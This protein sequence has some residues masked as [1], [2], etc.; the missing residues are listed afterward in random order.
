ME[1][2]WAGTHRLW[3]VTTRV[4]AEPGEPIS[5]NT[6]RAGGGGGVRVTL[7][8]NTIEFNVIKV[9]AAS[10]A[11][12]LQEATSTY[13]YGTAGQQKEAAHRLRF[14]STK[15]SVDTLGRLFWLNDQP[16][17][18]DLM[19]GLFGSPY[20]A[21]A[22]GAMQREISSPDHPITEDFLETLSKLQVAGEYPAEP[23]DYPAGLRSWADKW[24]KIYAH[25]R[26]LKKAAFTATVAALPKKVGRAHAITVE[27]L[28]TERSDWLV[29]ETASQL[30]RQLIAD[31]GDLPEWTR[32]DLIQNRWPLLEGPEMLPILV[33]IVSHPVPHF[34]YR[35]EESRSRDEALKH[36][37]ELDPA[38]GRSLI[39]RDLNDPKAQPSIS[40][41][42]LLSPKE[43]QPVVQQAVRRIETSD[44]RDVDYSIVELFADKSALGSLEAKF[45]VDNDHL[46]KGAGACNPR[47]VAMLRYFLRLDPKFGATAVQALLAARKVNGCDRLLED[48][49][50]SLP[51]VEQQAIRALDDTNPTVATEA[52]RALGQWGSAKAE[53]ALWARLRRFHQEWPNGVADLP[54]TDEDT[55]AQVR[56][57]D[58]LET[59][60]VRSTVSG[61]NWICDP[62]KLMRLRELVSWQNR[63]DLSQWIDAWE[64]TD[65]P[66]IIDPNYWGPEDRLSFSIMQLPYSNLDEEQIRVK[67]AQMPRGAKLYF[68]TFTAEQ[69]GS[70]VSM[71]KQQAVLQRLRKYAA[72]FDVIIDERP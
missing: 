33:E 34:P 6:F 20:R 53:P 24:D 66:L 35:T 5:L 12:Q 55:S 65:G 31:W 27:T 50:K 18:W 9:D 29:K 7:R 11:E 71:E 36:I 52:A 69:M 17:G 58:G 14:L 46:P 62:E 42:K 2:T 22:I 25:E 23:P 4:S 15:E 38:E 56:T 54:L 19:F 43:L 59:T 64:G 13:E 32:R 8:S 37:F 21:E 28:A 68:Q 48:L 3:V 26:D 49:G 1:T 57:L 70:P 39:L 67:L 40:L 51:K 72:Q 41:F 10:R 45:K 47:A 16:G 44:A 60:L 63:R 30:R 61:T